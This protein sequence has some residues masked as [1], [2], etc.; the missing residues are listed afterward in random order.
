MASGSTALYKV[1]RRSS[2]Q[3]E[4]EF[5]CNSC[6]HDLRQQCKERRVIELRTKH[7]DVEMYREIYNIL[8]QDTCMRHIEKLY[9]K[10]CDSCKFSFCDQCKKHQQLEILDIRTAYKTIRE[11][12]RDILQR[13]RSGNLYNE[14]NEIFNV[15]SKMTRKAQRL[16]D[17][18]VTVMCDYKIRM[19]YKCLMINHG[20]QRERRTLA[21][22]ENYEHRYEQ[23]ANRA[24]RLLFFIKNVFVPNITPYLTKHALLSLPEQI[25]KEDVVEFLS[26]VQIIDRG[27]RQTGSGSVLD[28]LILLF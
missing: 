19:R 26:E 4:T 3:G 11:Q 17:I 14:K 10:Y 21:R 5:Y 28:T 25:N 15:I 23:S 13:I 1:R 16:K 8:E 12:H 27:E 20:L 2:C 18:I 22:I 24:V 9:E 7:H 6:K